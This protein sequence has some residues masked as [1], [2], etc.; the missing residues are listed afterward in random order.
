MKQYQFIAHTG[1]DGTPYNSIASCQAGYDAGAE[2]LEVD[3]RETKD[4][5]AVLFHDNEPDV[6]RYTYEAWSAAG[7][8]PVEK[9]E[10]VLKLFLGKA[11]AFNL[12]LKTR[13]AYEAA[14][15]VVNKLD[16]WSQVYFTG[17]TDHLAHGSCA[18]HVIW[19]MPSIPPDVPDEDYEKCIRRYCKQAEQAGFAGVNAHYGSCRPT[20]IEYAEQRGLLVWIYTLPADESLLRSYIDMGVDAL[21]VTELSACM[22][23]KKR[24]A[25]NAGRS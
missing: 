14:V 9:L 3:V 6:S 21:S 1:C 8:D 7:H 10:T 25:S 20:L 19:N 16:S 17:V 24:W 15:A 13:E 5:V 18:K 23:L 22:E 12:D 2:V 4:N 11:V